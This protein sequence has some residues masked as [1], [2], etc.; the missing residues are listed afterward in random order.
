LPRI[1]EQTQ[2]RTAEYIITVHESR[3]ADSANADLLQRLRSDPRVRILPHAVDPFNFAMIANRAARGADGE[4]VCFLNDD[5]D[6]IDGGWLDGLVS[7]ME[8]DHIGAASA[9]LLYP[10]G[11]I[12]HD[13]VVVGLMGAG[14]HWNRFAVNDNASQ[15]AVRI[16]LRDVS[17]ATGACLLVRQDA[18]VSVGGFDERFS[19][20]YNDID[21]CLRLGAKGW[22]ILVATN[23]ELYHCETSS[24][25]R[26]ES[27][28][29]ARERGLFRTT[30]RELLASEPYFNP[31]VSLATATTFGLAVPPRDR[32]PR[33]YEIA[34]PVF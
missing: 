27:L 26:E 10:D 1:L 15:P 7:V 11:C 2:Y 23:I 21:L 28:A 34:S 29:A 30:W 13:G 8:N 19:V 24:L 31:N 3:L 18:F 22:R 32:S 9:R 4:F 6:I 16:K 5:I 17:A 14:E 20:G 25:S 12:Q 33:T